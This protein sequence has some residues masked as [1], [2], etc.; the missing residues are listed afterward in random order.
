MSG[1]EI[2][3]CRACDAVIAQC[4]CP[5][6]HPVRYVDNHNHDC[7]PSPAPGEPKEGFCSCDYPCSTGQGDE[8][9]C[10]GCGLLVNRPV[11][12]N[13][14][15]GFARVELIEDGS[16]Y[17]VDCGGMLPIESYRTKHE[18]DHV[19]W[20]INTAHASA[21]ARAVEEAQR[22]IHSLKKD[23]TAAREER[24]EA[25]R[26]GLPTKA[27]V[28]ERDALKVQIG[29]WQSTFGTSQLSH[30]RAAFDA[31]KKE[32]DGAI[33]DLRIAREVMDSLGG[34]KDA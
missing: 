9:R 5:G 22:E 31:L 6:P 4:R 8:E 12:A 26:W 33:E 18:A 3:K 32:R 21:V 17:E 24:R 10:S 20:K 16:G 2:V 28:E 30:A 34:V 1:H 7:K 29:A 14:M 27:L 11:D 13:K 23:L 19:A 15:M 25:E